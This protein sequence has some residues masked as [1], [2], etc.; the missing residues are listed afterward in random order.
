MQIFLYLKGQYH[1]IFGLGFLGILILLFAG[2]LDIPALI[3]IFIKAEIQTYRIY[4]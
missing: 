3:Y 2:L 1:E 4:Q